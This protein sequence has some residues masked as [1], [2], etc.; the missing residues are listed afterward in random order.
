MT[1]IIT[2][3]SAGGMLR[4]LPVSGMQVGFYMAP[5]YFFTFFAVSFSLSLVAS[6]LFRFIA[7][8]SPDMVIGNAFGGLAI[9]L[10]IVTSGE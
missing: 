7:C 8:M 2:Y 5:S 6:G 10:L 9:V 1:I 4:L 3:D